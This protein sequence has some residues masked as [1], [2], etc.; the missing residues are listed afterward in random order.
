LIET[1]LGKQTEDIWRSVKTTHGERLEEIRFSLRRRERANGPMTIRRISILE[2]LS[3]TDCI[4]SN[5]DW[6]KMSGPTY[7]VIQGLISRVTFH[8]E[9]PGQ[10]KLELGAE[11]Q[12]QKTLEY[13][14]L[15]STNRISIEHGNSRRMV[16][17][18]KYLAVLIIPLF[19]V[20]VSSR[21]PILR[22]R[23]LLKQPST[24]PE[25]TPA[26]K[27]PKKQLKTLMQPPRTDLAPPK[28]DP[29]TTEQLS[30]FDGSDPTKPIYVAIKGYDRS[31]MYTS[32]N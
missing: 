9:T 25:Q 11:I 10:F 19:Y 29:F 17:L 23:L 24:R 20:L 5:H 1:F 8:S 7:T 26:E 22:L 16:D 12:V 28:D 27:E 13:S 15:I 30:Q 21:F 2:V 14:Y 32:S 6:P 18:L 4:A 31:V 3:N